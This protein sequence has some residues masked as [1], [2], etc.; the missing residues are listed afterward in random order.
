MSSSILC[1]MPRLDFVLQR[2]GVE[3]AKQFAKH[4]IRVY[5]AASLATKK[6]TGSHNHPYRAEY[7][8]SAWSARYIL[9]H[10]MIF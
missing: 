3:G 9:R 4:L 8:K 7:V 6:K 1:E 5:R 2:D 10:N